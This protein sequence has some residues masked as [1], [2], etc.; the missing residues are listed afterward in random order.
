MLSNKASL[1]SAVVVGAQLDIYYKRVL[2]TY[3][4][5][6]CIRKSR[7]HTDSLTP[8][9]RLLLR[10]DI[11]GFFRRVCASRF[12]S[13]LFGCVSQVDDDVSPVGVGQGPRTQDLLVV[14][15]HQGVVG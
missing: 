12:S 14:V 6:A 7:S 2:P 15:V 4:A 11:V 13:R 5:R 8:L 3:C 9:P 10:R 1:M